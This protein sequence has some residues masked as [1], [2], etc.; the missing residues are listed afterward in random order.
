MHIHSVRK[1]VMAEMNMIPLIDVALILLIIFMVITPFLVR[2][3]IG[4]ELPKSAHGS[5]ISRENVIH[6]QIESGG[7]IILDGK[8]VRPSRL[9]NELAL[10]LSRSAKKTILVQADRSVSIEKVVKILD[11]SK[12]LGVG[13]LGIGVIPPV[14][15][16]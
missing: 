6:V 16:R 3:Q 13:R 14:R 7:R 1:G 9:E 12:K 4:V 10:R 5:N 15:K 11:V 2:S 8:H